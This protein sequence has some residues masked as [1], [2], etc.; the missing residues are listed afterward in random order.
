MSS[1]C[2]LTRLRMA[3]AIVDWGGAKLSIIY[4]LKNN[5]VKVSIGSL[6]G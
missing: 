5:R 4:D 6:S 1:K 2:V 3:D